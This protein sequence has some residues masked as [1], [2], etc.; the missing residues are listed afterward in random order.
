MRA[1][2]QPGTSAQ[3]SL[4]QMANESWYRTLFEYAP[5]GI[6]IADSLGYYL[7]ANPGIC[8]MLGYSREE[9]IGLQGSNIVVQ[10]ELEHIQPALDAIQSKADYQREWQLRRKDGSIFS[11]EVIATTMPDGNILAMVRDITLLK[12]REREIARLS[13]LY[14]AMTKINQAI[15]W[16]PNREEL[17][18]QACEILVEH[19]GFHMAWIGWENPETHQLVPL[20]H[21]GDE[22]NYIQSIKIYTDDQ[23]NGHG[24]SGIAFR[25]GRPFICN[26]IMNVEVTK[27]W[28]DELL[29]RGYQSSAA[30]PIRENSKVVG[31]MN[32]Y[33]DQLE[34]FHDKEIALL[35]E[36]TS[37]LSFA[38]EN[39]AREQ[40]R[41][42]AEAY[43]INEKQFSDTMIESMPGVLYFYD[44]QGRFLR[45]NKNFEIVSGY[46]DAEIKH[47]HPLDF[48]SD[49]NKQLLTNRITEVFI[50]GESFVEA[51]LI[52]KNGRAIPHFFT[53]RRVIFNGQ[54]CLVGMGIDITERLAAEKASHESEKKL[55]ALFEQAPLGIAVVDSKTGKFLNMNPQYSKIVGYAEDEMIQLDFM[56][57][58]HPDDLKDDLENMRRLHQGELQTFQMEKRLLRK[59]GSVVWIN[60]T[61]VPLWDEVNDSRQHIAMIEDITVRK[62]AEERLAESECK[63]RELVESA[64]SIILRWNSKG[65]ITF[66]NEFG[67]RFF[68]Y[69]ADEVIGLHVIGTIVPSTDSDGHD[70]EGL[71]AQVCADPV[72]FE[73]NINENMRRNGERVWIAWTNKIVL[74][75]NGQV[76][77]ILSVGTD[78]TEQRNAEM[79][80]RELNA[81][82]EQRVTNRT[83]ELHTA[84][85]RAEAAD[86]IKSAFLATMSHELRTPLNSIIGFTGIL[87]QGLA[88]PLNQE[89]NKQLGMVK[90]SA[91]HLLELINDV[92]DISKIE[93]GQLQVY[94][95][96]FDLPSLI[97]QVSLSLRPVAEKK[98]LVLSC[99]VDPNIKLLDGD[100]RRVKQILINLI[101]NAI[102]FTENGSVTVT[103]ELVEDSSRL[104]KGI[105]S[106]SVQL[107]VSD[108]GMGV[109]PEDLNVLFQPFRQ[110]DSGLTRQH[111]GTGLGLAICRRLL[112]LMGGDISAT[113]KWGIGSEFTVTFPLKR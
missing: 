84:L 85:V 22:N 92:L 3:G 109:K 4:Q 97:E 2:D 26:N 71:I 32:V 80:V 95:E 19:G 58:T 55:R 51:A 34:F 23:P 47:M 66:L 96:P 43:A 110:I 5:D 104:P 28:R 38:L 16:M 6:L 90:S 33:A 108:T 63:Y 44:N 61:C 8:N 79:A 53:G 67:Q 59:D 46:N 91:R 106:P 87:L 1:I 21:C 45:W 14:A 98:G 12:M 70:L 7:D 101:N 65:Y 41:R 88:G 64:N 48:F 81:S 93:A 77:E 99:I 105:S 60:L 107:R 49:E 40:T 31:T 36:V 69:S 42:Q 11:A 39:L 24:P 37:N 18:N 56:R 10:A 57:I 76:I 50:K 73:R 17:F 62:L 86:R 78:I 94:A 100:Q 89:Q 25:S 15:I 113:S 52:A 54:E 29:R 103:A 9:L 35:E 75:E 111:E 30:F 72:Q 82:L 83:E 27:P 74:D 20:A 112:E 102:K 13:R 68:G